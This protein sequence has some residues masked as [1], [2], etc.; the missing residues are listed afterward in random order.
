MRKRKTHLSFVVL[1]SVTADFVMLG[2]ML[3][4]S[5]YL[6]FHTHWFPAPESVPPFA[7]YLQIL[8]VLGL[9]FVFCMSHNGLYKDQ[10]NHSDWSL[11][12]GVVRASLYYLVAV[13]SLSFAYRA[14]SYS[15]LVLFLSTPLTVLAV[16]AQKKCI[17]ALQLWLCRVFNDYKRVLIV[18]NNQY[19]VDM[20]ESI[21]R[22]PRWGYQAV[23]F[24]LEDDSPDF[25][26]R[27]PV[28]GFV[29][30]L[31]RHLH[32]VDELIVAIPNL[33]RETLVPILLECET[34]LVSFKLIPDVFELITNR[35]E[36]YDILGFPVIGLKD[37]HLHHMRWRLLKRLFDLA[38]T[39][40][41]LAPS[42]PLMAVIA[43]LIRRDSKGPVFFRQE[44]CGQGRRPFKIIKFRTMR[45]DAETRTGPVW[46]TEN[47]PRCT[48]IGRF[49]RRTNLDELPQLFNVLR[50]EMSLV[51][52]RPERPHFVEK[53]KT[54]V[55]QYMLRHLVKP[56]I[57]GWAQVNGLRGNTPLEARIR[58]DLYY[59]ENWSILFDVKILILTLFARRNAY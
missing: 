57:T 4:L 1:L 5:F 59:I 32:D 54:D 15:R 10:W 20:Y 13:M 8:P 14:F 49:L 3:A 30:D 9:V 23:G 38:L 2:A 6:R 28:R 17:S 21:L 33:K 47:D 51:G 43:V 35:V 58:H 11:L 41:L 42:L 55:P 26:N 40:A 44:R 31:A 36:I 39:L 50:G 48:P 16:F 56:G 46:A 7:Y 25:R 22:N 12:S 34:Q 18:G 37:I 52:P 27:Y 53:F 24:L 45:P 29:R 19:A